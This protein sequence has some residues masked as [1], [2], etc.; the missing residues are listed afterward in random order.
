MTSRFTVWRGMNVRAALRGRP[1][2]RRVFFL[3]RT[4]PSGGAATQRRRYIHSAPNDRDR[5]WAHFKTLPKRA[6]SEGIDWVSS[7]L[8]VSPAR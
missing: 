3:R 4:D 2:F 5:K 1:S 6:R 8:S 7:L